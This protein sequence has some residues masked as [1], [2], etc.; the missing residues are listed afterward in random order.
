M[1][2][3]WKQIVSKLFAEITKHV[4]ISMTYW[5]AS[6]NIA[7]KT[8]IIIILTHNTECLVIEFLYATAATRRCIFAK[9]V[10][11]FQQSTSNQTQRNPDKF[12][13]NNVITIYVINLITYYWT[14]RID[15]CQCICLTTY[16]KLGDTNYTTQWKYFVSYLIC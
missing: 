15:A 16:S 4:L 3:A 5:I 10:Y 9:T 6:N 13:R 12:T 7:S 11:E 8:F 1:S 14:A 2:D